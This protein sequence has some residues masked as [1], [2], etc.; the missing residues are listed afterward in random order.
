MV[1]LVATLC[2]RSVKVTT[3]L[4]AVRLV[5][6]CKVP[7][8]ALRA[9][10]T[11]VVLSLLRRLPNWS[12]IRMTG[13]CEKATPAV[14]VEEGCVCKVNRAA[15][16]ALTVNTTLVALRKPLALAVS[17]LFVPAISISRS[18]N[19]T[20]PLPAP[21][22]MLSV[23]VPCNGPVPESRLAVTL[24]LPGKPTVELFPNWSWELI[25]GDVPK[26]EPAVALPGA[27]VKARRSA[28]AGLIVIELDVTGVRAPLVN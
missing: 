16:P 17:C 19:K 4:T 24:R 2:A 27:V 8:P 9:A 22:P 18:V 10:V 12:S 1:M 26:A 15:A 11:T 20:A 21:V 25:T 23:V 5:V 3:P 6:P 14:A 7:L 28:V 13:C